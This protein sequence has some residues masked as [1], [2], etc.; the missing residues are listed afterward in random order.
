MGLLLASVT[1]SNHLCYFVEYTDVAGDQQRFYFDPFTTYPSGHPQ[2][3]PRTHAI[4]TPLPMA[5]VR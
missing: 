1:A 3:R 2:V 4:R 5:C